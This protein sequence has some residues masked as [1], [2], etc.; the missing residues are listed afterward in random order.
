MIAAMEC[1]RCG[2]SV[3]PGYLRLGTDSVYVASMQSLEIS[4]LGVLICLGCGH[5]ELQAVNP[6][7]L[8]REDITDEEIR[9]YTPA[10]RY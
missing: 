8:A 10:E 1:P 6:E 7:K 3:V 5:I 2:A 9:R 4:S